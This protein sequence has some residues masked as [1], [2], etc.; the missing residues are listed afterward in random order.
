MLRQG[1][2]PEFRVISAVTDGTS[3]IQE[4]KHLKPDIVLC[5]IKLPVLDGLAAGEEI[6]RHWPTTKLVY[7]TAEAAPATAAKAFSFGAEGYLLKH[8]TQAELLQAL[9]VVRDGGQH[10]TRH[11][12]DGSPDQLR[13]MIQ[14]DMPRHLTE[15]TRE[16]LALLVQGL[17]MKE[18]ARRLNITPRTVAFHKYHARDVLELHN[19][20]DLIGYAIKA[21][22]LSRAGNVAERE[23]PDISN[24]DSR[25]RL[26]VRRAARTIGDCAHLIAQAKEVSARTADLEEQLGSIHNAP[27]A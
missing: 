23:R 6:K 17:S 27:A 1:L 21:G 14:A 20:A 5:G 15:R 10:L 25:T 11:I 16:V 26:L 24:P 8:C 2:P 3:L 22:L 19:N 12:A 13:A 9:R 7:L 4:V 18:V